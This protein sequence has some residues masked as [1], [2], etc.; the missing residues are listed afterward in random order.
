MIN[1]P[2]VLLS[3]DDDSFVKILQRRPLGAF[4]IVITDRREWFE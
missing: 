4:F 1:Q 3:V 2:E